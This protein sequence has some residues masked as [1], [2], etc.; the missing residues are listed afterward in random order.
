MKNNISCEVVDS[1]QVS[2]SHQVEK[3]KTNSNINTNSLEIGENNG[4]IQ[5]ISSMSYNIQN[6][7]GV[8]IG[9]VINVKI[10]MQNL[11]V[12]PQILHD[13]K[14]V[15]KKTPTIKEM[16]NSPERLSSGF[17]DHICKYFGERWRDV[18]L[19]LDI[20]QLYVERIKEDELIFK[21]GGTKEVKN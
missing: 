9:N 15:Y 16:M 4:V 18:T 5:N 12:S 1:A 21:K 19:L 8:H 2:S 10:P 13:E 11:Q 14:N 17:L 3:Y 20:D 7:H 6:S